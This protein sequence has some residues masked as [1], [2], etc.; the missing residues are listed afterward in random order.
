[1][2]G[3]ARTLL[4]AWLLLTNL[5]IAQSV[6]ITTEIDTQRVPVGSQVTLQISV[7]GEVNDAEEPRFP[8]L[9]AFSVQQAGVS[10][11]IS[12]INGQSSGASIYTYILTPHKEGHFTIPPITVQVNGKSEHTQPI[13]VDVLPAAPGQG[14]PGS[15]GG[16][17]FNYP[18]TH[19]PMPRRQR[20]PF[21][22]GLPPLAPGMD[23]WDPGSTAP[24]SSPTL[25][26][27]P[28]GPMVLVEAEAFPRNPY[29]NQP[30]VYTF[31]FLHRVNIDGNPNFEPPNTTGFI[32][33]DLS[34]NTSQVERDGTRY[35]VSEAKMLF[36]PTAAGQYAIGPVRLTCRLSLNDLAA[37]DNFS[38]L[39]DTVRELVAEALPVSVRNLPNKGR[40]SDFSGGVGNFSVKASLDKTRVE[41]GQPL[42]LRLEV[43]GDGHPD[44]IGEPPMPVSD[45]FKFYKGKPQSNIS[46]NPNFHATKTFD[47]PVVAVRPG[48]LKV[49]AIAFSYFDPR[50]NR[51]ETATTEPIEVHVT[52]STK[53]APGPSSSPTP[54]ASETPATRDPNALRGL[55][56]IDSLKSP[57]PEPSPLAWALHLIPWLGLAL[58]HWA[59]TARSWWAARSQAR[60]SSNLGRRTCAALR[61]LPNE[62]A[63]QASTMLYTYLESRLSTKLAGVSLQE[64][65]RRLSERGVEGDMCRQLSRL[66]ADLEAYRYAP[67]TSSD[68]ALASELRER[69]AL[70]L[71]ELEKKL[72]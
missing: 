56:T 17:A 31:R 41:Q 8:P 23:P 46:R 14:S 58:W 4:A 55:K 63:E 39:A 6:E 42:S 12:V 47:I 37:L 44:L 38:S 30:V 61:K 64:L 28:Q 25:P 48:N 69:S 9:E 11:Q 45:D 52:P 33:E 51:Y 1:M 36:F 57:L 70:L 54:G 65:S 7:K 72:R 68:S 10:R 71:T 53:P 67:R 15:P 19:R 13:V 16:P 62:R 35:S 20:N 40:P 43:S 32:K 59:R 27:R 3:Q 29:V 49:P 50:E 21:I 66:M 60:N 26:Q 2:L 22:P 24:E 18:G 34:Q 5:A